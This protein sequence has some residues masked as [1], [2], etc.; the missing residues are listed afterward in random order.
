MSQTVDY[1]ALDPSRIEVW[2][3]ALGT[4]LDSA[5]VNLNSG[6]AGIQGELKN[7]ITWNPFTS[8]DKLAIDTARD[9]ASGNISAALS[10]IADRTAELQRLTKDLRSVAAG[11]AKSAA[12]IRL[13]AVTRVIDA[14]TRSVEALR[15]LEKAIETD[16]KSDDLLKKL[17]SLIKAT[18]TLRN[19]V[20]A[21]R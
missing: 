15:D 10:S 5:A 13:E 12:D 20:E 9:I 6:G 18:Q 11:A 14:T 3:E 19:E 16:L 7:F 4:L 2:A 21:S 17:R 1:S 8:L